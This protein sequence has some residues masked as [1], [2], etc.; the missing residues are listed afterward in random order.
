MKAN[1]HPKLYKTTIRCSC[2]NTFET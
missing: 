2:G 1:T